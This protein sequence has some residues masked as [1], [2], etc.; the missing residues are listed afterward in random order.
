[1]DLRVE[2][3][4]AGETGSRPATAVVVA[5]PD[6]ET[7][8]AGSRLPW[9][10]Q[11]WLV[12]VTDGSPLDGR[13]ASKHGM[14][15]EQYRLV[16]RR[17]LE[18]ALSLAL[19]PVSR[20]IQFGYVDQRASLS[21]PAL[22]RRL[23]RLFRDLEIERVVTQP[24]EGGHPDH[25]ATAFGVHAAAGILRRDGIP[26]PNIIEMTSYHTGPCGIETFTFLPVVPPHS[27]GGEAITF[28]LSWAERQF[29]SK[30]LG[31]FATQQ[32]TLKCFPID[33]E[34]F[35][36]A[37]AYDFTSPPHDGRLFYEQFS[38]GMT[39][40]RF[41]ELAAQALDELEIGPCATSR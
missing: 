34:R 19:V 26:A 40:A 22:S 23:A 9:L 20:A 28:E 13:D 7:I 2:F 12:H 10:R 27:A 35:R 4:C 36:V 33:V 39:G 24:Y 31:L 38:W 17:E 15:S 21:L 11:A 41:R 18:A 6:D 1:M 3:L 25:D 16:R 32:E 29:K 37:P 14:T 8:G 30:M 5:H